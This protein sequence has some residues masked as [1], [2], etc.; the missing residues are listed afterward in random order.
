MV[1]SDLVWVNSVP[2]LIRL[3][4]IQIKPLYPSDKEVK[5]WKYLPKIKDNQ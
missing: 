5:C 3:K 4:L 2:V 1:L